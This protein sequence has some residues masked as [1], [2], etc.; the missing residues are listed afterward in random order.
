MTHASPKRSPVTH[1]ASRT[2]TTNQ[3]SVAAT[4][5]ASEGSMR[6]GSTTPR[7]I[8]RARG[9]AGTRARGRVG[10]RAWAAGRPKPGSPE[11]RKPRAAATSAGRVAERV[12]QRAVDHGS[13]DPR[14]RHRPPEAAVV[15][16][17]AVV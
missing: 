14:A 11:A 5:P 10:A 6:A 16:Y 13:D 3:P 1:A 2:L 17:P 12:E 8:R 9:L 4:R 7:S 15:R